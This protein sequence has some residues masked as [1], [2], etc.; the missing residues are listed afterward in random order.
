MPHPD[1]IHPTR[2]KVL[3]IILSLSPTE[4]RSRPKCVVLFTE[5]EVGI[6]FQLVNAEYQI[7]PEISTT[8]SNNFNGCLLHTYILNLYC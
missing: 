1:M 3:L 8:V 2:T 4:T 6:L 5:L 7:K